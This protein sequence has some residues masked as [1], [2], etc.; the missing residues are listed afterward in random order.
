M[1]GSCSF[2]QDFLKQ[3]EKQSCYI[4]VYYD[5]KCH[6]MDLIVV[7]IFDGLTSHILKAHAQPRSLLE[8]D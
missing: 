3:Q 6:H 4:A 2:S 8:D 7:R 5:V 1:I